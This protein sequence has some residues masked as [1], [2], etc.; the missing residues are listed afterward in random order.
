MPVIQDNEFGKIVVRRTSG[1]SMRA[2]L[3]PDGSLRLSVPSFAPMFMVRRM[4]SGSRSD[5]RKIVET[6]PLF[7]V[8]D[9]MTIG[10]SHSLHVRSGLVFN[11]QRR[12][13]QLI[14]TLNADKTLD[15]DTVKEEVRRHMR[16]ILR[17]EA[18]AHLPKRLEYLARLHGY[19]FSS[20][21]FTHAS[22]RWGS[23]NNK[24][25]ISLNIALMTLPFELIDYVLIHEL[26][27]TVHL[28]HSSAFWKEVSRVDEA[29]LIH[30]K[31]LKQYNPA[32]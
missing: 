9:G 4:I 23:C 20:L 21:R 29:Y 32:I 3:A 6:R 11:V 25:A 5:L 28:N 8:K 14:V 15:S 17:K 16:L 24:K 31:K 2:S 27:H 12:G 10:K 30:R 7:V 1:S 18:K 26:A 19:E 13:L 22:S